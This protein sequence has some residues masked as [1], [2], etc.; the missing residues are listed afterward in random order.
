MGFGFL[1]T[2]LTALLFGLAPAWRASRPG[3][4]EHLK[5]GRGAARG[6]RIDL[7]RWVVVAQIA[8]SVVLLVAAG[9]LLRSLWNLNSVDLGFNPGHILTAA[10]DLDL[11]GYDRQRGRL[12]MQRLVE[13]LQAQPGVGSVSLSDD[14]PAAGLLS[15]RRPVVFEGRENDP[16]IS[17][18]R[19][20][21]VSQSYFDTLG[22][23]LLRGRGFDNRDREG[24]VA[25]AMVSQALAER[26]WPGQD[27]IGQKVGLMGLNQWSEV[28]GMVRG[29]R[30]AG[31]R[32]APLGHVYW[33][34]AQL[35]DSNLLESTRYILLGC[36][37]DPA[38]LWSRRRRWKL[39]AGG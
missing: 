37:S 16:P 6:S 38:G 24:S 12:F 18:I 15:K 23:P 25:V 27:P 36:D 35:Y 22:I 34:L 7:Q 10:F 13:G 26:R 21:V 8:L 9:L 1:L 3:L 4:T 39:V 33:P 20:S 32:E 29:H 2:A 11:Q 31:I 19:Q 14:L 5:L 28:I 17:G 30:H